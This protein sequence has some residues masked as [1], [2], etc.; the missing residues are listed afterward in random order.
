LAWAAAAHAPQQNISLSTSAEGEVG[1][2]AEVRDSE[3][4]EAAGQQVTNVA[5]GRF[6][7]IECSG[8]LSGFALK[9]EAHVA[10]LPVWREHDVCDGF[11]CDTGIVH[12]VLEDF[13]ELGPDGFREALSAVRVHGCVYFSVRDALSP[14]AGE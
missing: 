8:L 6:N 1:V 9:G 11:H 2:E 14:G 10:F 12:F 5:F 3:H 4:V 13:L 7:G